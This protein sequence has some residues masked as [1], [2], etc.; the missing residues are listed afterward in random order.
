MSPS[1]RRRRR[2]RRRRRRVVVVVL[3]YK[4]KKTCHLEDFVI[5]ADHRVKIKES[6]KIN[7]YLELARKLK[8]LWNMRAMI[9]PI[10]V[11]TLGMIY[12]SLQRVLE[13]LEIKGIIKTIQTTALLRLA[14]IFRRVWET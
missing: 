13:E 12:K 6:K 7:K 11:S 9:V 2:G 1:R 10:I 5:P 4:K 3:I 8:K 14:R